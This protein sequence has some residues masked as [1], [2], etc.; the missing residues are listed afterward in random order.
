MILK[1]TVL[2]HCIVFP[3]LKIQITTGKQDTSACKEL[4]QPLSRN[5][6]AVRDMGGYPRHI[7]L[8]DVLD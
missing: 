8:N 7:L 1:H 4:L 3:A 6:Q 5:K 2:L